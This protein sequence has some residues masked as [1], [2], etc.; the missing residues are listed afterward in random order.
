MKNLVISLRI[1]VV[2]AV[3]LGLLYPLAMTA[4]SV[5]V[6]PHQAGGE[7][8]TRQ[9]QAVGSILIAQKFSR[10]EYFWPRPSAIDFNPLP[11]GGSNLG[12]AS[13]DLKKAVEERR[14]KLKAAHPEQTGEPP[15]DLLFASGSGL[16]P[17]ISPEAAEYQAQRVA[18]TRSLALEEVRRLIESVRER[19]QIGILGEST[20]NVLV[21]DLA[22]DE[23]QG[24]K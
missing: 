21:L 20:V 4:I 22:L 23:A 7:F 9:G 15:Q 14:L 2:F 24:K 3:L 11:S 19:R 17:H 13:Q 12:L 1:S 16:D 8:V 6:F 18:R 5:L 10:P